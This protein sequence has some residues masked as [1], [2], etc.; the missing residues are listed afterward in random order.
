MVEVV[1]VIA[2]D[3]GTNPS[4]GGRET[5]Q[6]T[7]MFTCPEQSCTKTFI[8]Y[9]ALERH[10]EFGVH[11]RITLQDRAKIS[12]AKNLQEGQTMKQ[13][14]LPVC[15]APVTHRA[16]DTCQMG[17]ALKSSP[18]KVRFTQEQKNFLDLKYNL[19]EQTGKKSS[20]EDVAMQ[21]RRARGQDGKR[22]FAVDDF[23]TA[24]QITSYFRVWP[25]RG[26]MSGRGRGRHRRK[27]K[28]DP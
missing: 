1:T 12:Y 23:L 14:S 9:S 4:S 24:Q 16:S 5:C 11:M 20:G 18:R 3:D 13:Q 15:G 22:L 27:R 10:C 7:R 26:R 2:S 8:R 21:M 17:W 6:T 25:P 28:L 19:G